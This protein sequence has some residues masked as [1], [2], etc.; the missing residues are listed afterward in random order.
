MLHVADGIQVVNIDHQGVGMGVKVTEGFALACLDPVALDLVCAR[1]MFKTIPMAEAK[2]LHKENKLST[3]FLQRV[4][5]AKSD[6]QN[7]I[8]E[9]GVDSPLSRYNLYKYAETRRLGRQKYYVVGWD[10]MM[11]APLASLKGHLGRVEDGKFSEI[12]TSEFYYNPTKLLW[13]C[14][15][16]VLSYLEANDSLT[17]STYRE[18]VLAAFDQN[19]D[20]VID[21]DEMGQKGFWHPM[22]RL[23]SYGMHVVGTEKYGFL[24]GSFLMSALTLKYLNPQWNAEGHDFGK[25]YLVVPAAAAAFR[26]SQM[27]LESPDLFFPAMTWGKGK[28]PSV[29]L[30]GYV[31]VATVIYGPGFPMKVGSLSLYGCVFQYADKTL[32]GGTYTRSRGPMSDPEAANRY[33][34]A[35]S[36]GA[37]PLNFV[38][39]VP[40]G[41]GTM[42]GRS[43]PNVE[44]T[45]DPKKVLT[46]SFSDCQEL[47]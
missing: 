16:T 38:F 11:G 47:W 39:Y 8:T 15:R 29:P 37:K 33:I 30:A 18:E 44:E 5:I 41:F 31:A 1:Y 45:A 10:V 19:G 24:R 46:A 43:V 6:G 13:D 23:I 14:Q 17:G 25:E 9:T 20:G 22:L 2:K 27:Q 35:I 40:V 3:D 34:E 7:I 21:Y 36:Q 26:M 12:M 32:N 28:W 4:P 42:I